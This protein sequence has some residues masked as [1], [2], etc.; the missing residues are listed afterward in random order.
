MLRLKFNSN[1]RMRENVPPAPRSTREI[2]GWN[3]CRAE[4]FFTPVEF[5]FVV[6]HKY[7]LKYKYAVFPSNIFN[8]GF[9]EGMG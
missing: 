7:K 8:N 4:G 2:S 3:P 1:S 5:Y 9:D 6:E